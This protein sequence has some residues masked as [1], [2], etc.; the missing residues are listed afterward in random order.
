MYNREWLYNR[1]YGWRGNK[2]KRQSGTASRARQRIPSKAINRINSAN[3]NKN[4][5]TYQT[6][7]QLAITALFTR[8]RKVD[9]YI[10]EVLVRAV[11]RMN[12][13]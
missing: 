5:K 13:Q 3:N 11:V 6:G 1:E 7:T 12:D 8:K 9:E 4:I 10:I 2:K